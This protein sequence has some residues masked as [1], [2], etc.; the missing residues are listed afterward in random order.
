VITGDYGWIRG[1]SGC[2]TVFR[3]AEAA[4][5]DAAVLA[6]TVLDRPLWRAAFGRPMGG[7]SCGGWWHVICCSVGRCRRPMQNM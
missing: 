5:V 3:W 1:T 2:P 4:V 7:C 6:A